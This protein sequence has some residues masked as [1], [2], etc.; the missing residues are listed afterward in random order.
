MKKKIQTETEAIEEVLNI[1]SMMTFIISRF[2]E[3]EFYVW[4]IWAGNKKKRE[5][6]S[7]QERDTLECFA[8][9]ETI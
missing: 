2:W 3:G 7:K 8:V 1:V 9:D 5:R 6:E 4:N